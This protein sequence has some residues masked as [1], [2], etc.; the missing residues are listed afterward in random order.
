MSGSVFVCVCVC[1][2]VC[3]CVCMCASS[4]L[5]QAKCLLATRAP[6]SIKGTGAFIPDRWPCV[7]T[8]A[9]AHTHRKCQCRCFHLFWLV[10][11]QLGL[12][13]ELS[14]KHPD[15]CILRKTL[16]APFLCARMLLALLHHAQE[17]LLICLY[18]AK[19]TW[20]RWTLPLKSKGSR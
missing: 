4:P 6:V 16:R 5:C 9:R 18:G 2:C 13:V 12:K 1:V 3:A 20:R 19:E 7:H 17:N 11:L 15:V 8:H 10:S 14:W